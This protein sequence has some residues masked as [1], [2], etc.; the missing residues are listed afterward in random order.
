MSNVDEIG[1]ERCGSVL[2]STSA[3]LGRVLMSRPGPGLGMFGVKTWLS[4]IIIGDCVSLV[5]RMLTLMSVPSHL[6]GDVK[7]PLRTTCTLAVTIL[8]GSIETSAWR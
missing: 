5:V 1:V 6:I 3:L 2:V 4:I 8:N 7:E